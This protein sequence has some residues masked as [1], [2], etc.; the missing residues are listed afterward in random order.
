MKG[1]FTI[2]P[3]R[4]KMLNIVIL[5][6]IVCLLIFTNKSSICN[7]LYLL[8]VQRKHTTLNM[9]LYSGG[10]FQFFTTSN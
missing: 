4:K 8:R 10:M 7:K 6:L 2:K 9:T 3:T 5:I 1:C